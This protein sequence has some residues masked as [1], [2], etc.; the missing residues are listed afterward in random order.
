M[1]AKLVVGNVVRSLVAQVHF[2]HCMQR[3]AFSTFKT[4]EVVGDLIASR[5]LLKGF[6]VW[7][8]LSTSSVSTIHSAACFC[9]PK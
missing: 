7:R 5:L 1:V 9:S 3:A 2:R 4:T 8:L 6:G